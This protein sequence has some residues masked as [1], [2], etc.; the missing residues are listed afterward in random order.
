MG[1]AVDGVLGIRDVVCHQIQILGQIFPGEERSNDVG[2]SGF[3]IEQRSCGGEVFRDE[4]SGEYVHVNHQTR[5]HEVQGN[6][7]DHV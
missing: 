1:L 6:P 5:T 3:V 4:F 7:P 2:V